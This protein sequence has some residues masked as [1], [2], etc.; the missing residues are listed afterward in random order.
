MYKTNIIESIMLYKD[1]RSLLNGGFV[2]FEQIV[3]DQNTAIQFNLTEST[4][5]KKKNRNTY[6][7]RKTKWSSID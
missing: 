1:D 3:R 2:A 5:M 6:R 7:Q 4:R